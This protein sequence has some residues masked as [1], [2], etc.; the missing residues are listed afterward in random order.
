MTDE[1]VTLSPAA[2]AI[3][4]FVLSRAGKMLEDESR[5]I[6]VEHEFFL[7]EGDGL[8]ATH[9]RSQDFLATL[10]DVSTLIKAR[11]ECAEPVGRY[12]SRMSADDGDDFSDH[13]KYDHHPHLL[14]LSLAPS[15]D[16]QDVRERLR[17]M[18][19]A[20]R[21]AA[22]RAKV[23]VAHDAFL[24]VDAAHP[25]TRSCLSSFRALRRYRRTLMRKRGIVDKSAEN[26]A[27]VIAA[28]QIH[29]GGSVWLRDP[30]A[31]ENLYRYERQARRFAYDTL[32]G[33]IHSHYR[34][35]WS[36]YRKVFANSRLVGLRV[37]RPW[38]LERWFEALALAPMAG[39]ADSEDAADAFAHRIRPVNESLFNDI[40]DLQAI[41]P[42]IF[43]TI[44]F[45][46]DPAQ[47]TAEA[48]VALA[49]FRQNC[50]ASSSCD[51]Q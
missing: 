46:G 2:A 19:E 50:V 49:Q 29:V 37:P 40:R 34:R 17:T 14:E 33:P 13:V 23:R 8:P 42:R 48:I 16:I 5:T 6:G 11:F 39:L 12:V 36:G 7:I 35:R 47:P 10:A 4:N 15:Y 43:G 41:R 28:T 26:Y 3:R 20:I 51:S 31:M 1:E 18:F 22:R 25:R 27:S 38:T 24:E 30:E 45:R 9:E 32:S 21:T 44:E